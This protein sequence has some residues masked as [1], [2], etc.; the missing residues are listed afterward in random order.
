MK[1]KNVQGLNH[2]KNVDRIFKTTTSF[3]IKRNNLFETISKGDNIILVSES[4]NGCILSCKGKLFHSTKDIL[5]KNTKEIKPEFLFEETKE[6]IRSIVQNEVANNTESK[7]NIN[8]LIP[9]QTKVKY[10]YLGKEQ[11]GII[12]NVTKNSTT[13]GAPS[14]TIKIDN[15]PISLNDILEIVTEP[16]IE[17]GQET[18]KFLGSKVVLKSDTTQEN[19]GIIMSNDSEGVNINWS[20]GG[21]SYH[22]L[23]QVTFL[24]KQND[25]DN[26][27]TGLSNAWKNIKVPNTNESLTE[28]TNTDKKKVADL[29]NIKKTNKGFQYDKNK[30][31]VATKQDT[32][33]N[34]LKAVASELD[35][36][37]LAGAQQTASKV[38]GAFGFEV[39]KHFNE[40]EEPV[41]EM[42]TDGFKAFKIP[43]DKRDEY[44]I[45]KDKLDAACPTAVGD[46]GWDSNSDPIITINDMSVFSEQNQKAIINFMNRIGAKD[47]TDIYLNENTN[48]DR[49]EFT[50]KLVNDYNNLLK[51]N[52]SD[53]AIQKLADIHNADLNEIKT[54]LLEGGITNI[55]LDIDEDMGAPIAQTSTT[56]GSGD[57]FNTIN[58][59]KKEKVNEAVPEVTEIKLVE[60]PTMDKIY[61]NKLLDSL[62]AL[63]SQNKEFNFVY[64]G[65]VLTIPNLSVLT[66]Y[67]QEVIKTLAKKAGFT[68][69][70]EEDAK[71]IVGIP[72]VQVKT[73]NTSENDKFHEFVDNGKYKVGQH[74]LSCDPYH[75]DMVISNNEEDHIWGYDIP[76]GSIV[77]ITKGQELDFD[78]VV[79][80]KVLELG[81][82]STVPFDLEPATKGETYYST[83]DSAFGS[84]NIEYIDI[85]GKLDTAIKSVK[86]DVNS[87][88]TGFN[89]KHGTEGPTHDPYSYTEYTFVKDNKNFKIHLGLAQY[90]EVDGKKIPAIGEDYDNEEAF[91]LKHT[92]ITYNDLLNLQ[93]NDDDSYEEDPMGSIADYEAKDPLLNENLNAGIPE[94]QVKN[95]NDTLG[96]IKSFEEFNT[97]APNTDEKWKELDGIFMKPKD[98]NEAAIPKD[99]EAGNIVVDGNGQEHEVRTVTNEFILLRN[100]KEEDHK[101]SHEVFNKEYSIVGNKDNTNE[102][103][104][105]FIKLK[106]GADKAINDYTQN[107]DINKLEQDIIAL[108]PNHPDMDNFIPALKEIMAEVAAGEKPLVDGSNSLYDWIMDDDFELDESNIKVPLL[109]PSCTKKLSKDQLQVYRCYN[110]S[111]TEYGL[112]AQVKQP[113]DGPVKNENA[114]DYI[115]KDSITELQNDIDTTIK[116]IDTIK[117]NLKLKEWNWKNAIHKGNNSLVSQYKTDL[118]NLNKRLKEEESN[119]IGFQTKLKA[120]KPKVDNAL[121]NDVAG[122]TNLLL[123]AGD[124]DGGKEYWE[125]LTIPQRE[126]L[127]KS[128]NTQG[129][130]FDSSWDALSTEE[131]DKVIKA[132]NIELSKRLNE[133]NMKNYKVGDILPHGSKVLQKQMSFSGDKIEIGTLTPNEAERLNVNL[134]KAGFNSTYNYSSGIYYQYVIVGYKLPFDHRKFAEIVEDSLGVIFVNSSKERIRDVNKF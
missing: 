38:K 77:Y 12:Q 131:Q 48:N 100:E 112:T 87:N 107:K 134:T 29:F 105:S 118:D 125:K 108:F 101:I 90:I 27:H 97:T 20:K 2:D 66:P 24:E 65:D 61:V 128:T 34:N 111:C 132:L 73:E 116:N 92:G 72:E 99:V 37:I 26:T 52:T 114:S 84:G 123:Q 42:Y 45:F 23:S 18:D 15:Q 17:E 85:K 95:N 46:S 55:T 56:P 3:V 22:H 28:A 57:Q 96:P 71:T 67:N 8:D 5:S 35:P 68:I 126:E 47:V 9:N 30:T 119:L 64:S 1:I 78:T 113:M 82:E 98:T 74:G 110:I 109:C 53:Q 89:V 122:N 50:T 103:I 44:F 51:S 60:S 63:K 36:K 11:I 14:Y 104:D 86:E 102:N 127:I 54:T 81:D 75:K 16:K 62:K 58:L 39:P 13:P 88:I 32:L 80:I 21:S 130:N 94:V 120:S 33:G 49:T 79:I 59:K 10:N 91:I 40:T 41:K 7:I 25:S 121:K 93:R 83:L 76:E 117:Q 43:D 70:I 106:D 133:T 4:A 6:E 31:S 19:P 129:V 115:E 124:I 69:S